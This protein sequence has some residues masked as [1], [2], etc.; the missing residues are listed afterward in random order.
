MSARVSG[1]GFHKMSSIM[2]TSRSFTLLTLSKTCTR[3][4]Q[5]RVLGV[6][7]RCQV[8]NKKRK[9]LHIQFY[10]SWFLHPDNLG[11]LPRQGEA[12]AMRALIRRLVASLGML[13]GKTR[14]KNGKYPNH[15][16]TWAEASLCFYL[17]PSQDFCGIH[18]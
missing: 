7:V 15:I 8:F 1:F 9:T 12:A 18:G 4:G 14:H 17:Y 13:Q 16:P 3:N 10:T 6:D 5:R 2:C 11:D